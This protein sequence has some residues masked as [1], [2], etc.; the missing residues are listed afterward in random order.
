MIPVAFVLPVAGLRLLGVGFQLGL[1]AYWMGKTHS[2]LPNV[3]LAASGVLFWGEAESRA[4][5]PWAIDTGCV[6]ALLG[7]GATVFAD[8]A[9]TIGLRASPAARVLADV[10]LFPYPMPAPHSPA[11]SLSIVVKNNAARIPV[12]SAGESRGKRLLAYFD[13][14]REPEPMRLGIAASIAQRYCRER[15][16]WGQVGSLVWSDDAGDRPIV[17]FECG[18]GGTVSHLR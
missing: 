16:Y 8:G 14:A 15:G 2:V 6:I 11:G 3:I 18:T 10:A 4:R 7:V 17:E 1:H 12:P 9:A 5:R 13:R